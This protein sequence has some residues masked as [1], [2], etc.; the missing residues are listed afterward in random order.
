MKIGI[1]AVEINRFQKSLA[2][3]G[4]AFIKQ[5]FHER[6][7]GKSLDVASLAGKFAAKEAIFK[8]GYLSKPDTLAVMILKQEDGTP[9]AADENYIRIK[10]LELS[11]THTDTMAIAVA[12]YLP[13]EK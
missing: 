3:G 1:D 2:N 8:S 12:I 6:E 9:Y 13:D 7:L 4:S 11:I 5:N 10:G